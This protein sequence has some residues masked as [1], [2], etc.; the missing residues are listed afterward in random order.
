MI[1]DRLIFRNHLQ[2]GEKLA[3]AVHQ[4]WFSMYKAGFKIAFFGMLIPAVLFLLFPTPAAL[5]IFGAWLIIG[6]LRFIYE[7]IDWYLDALLVTDQG[8]IDLDWR[9]FF[10]KSFSRVEY[11]KIVGISYEKVGFWSSIFN[12]GV[13]VIS[14]DGQSQDQISLPQASNPQRAE[15]EIMF[16]REKY[17]QARSMEDEKVLKN[18]LTGM[19]KRQVR[20]EREGQNKLADML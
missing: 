7:I 17:M 10:D 15:R 14:R 6:F 18:I 13:L 2:P 4:H 5:W 12:F 20:N 19:V 8:I 3:Y 11:E 1:L 16:T 9:G